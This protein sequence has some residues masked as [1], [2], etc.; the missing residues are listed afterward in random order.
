ML[1][2]KYKKHP[3]VESEKPAAELKHELEYPE[4]SF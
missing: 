4:K 1:K 3:F 2:S